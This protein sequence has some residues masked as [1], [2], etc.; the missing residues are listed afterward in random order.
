MQ[1][2]FANDKLQQLYYHETE[3]WNYPPEVV[4]AFFRVMSVIDAVTDERELYSFKS[5]R[6][7][8]LVGDR[9]G[10]YS[11]RLNDQWRLIIEIEAVG[12][13]NRIVV[14]EIADYH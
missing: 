3:A 1:F 12:S 2:R 13:Q 9:A 8:K 10:Q 14:V 11:L 6:F 4:K 5:R 7:E